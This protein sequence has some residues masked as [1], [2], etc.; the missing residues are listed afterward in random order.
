M[1]HQEISTPE[2]N[3]QDPDAVLAQTIA[4]E[5]GWKQDGSGAVYDEHGVILAPS[6]FEL[7]KVMRPLGWFTPASAR[8]S[9]VM[10]AEVPDPGERSQ[11]VRRRA[12]AM[13][14]Y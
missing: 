7:A 5:T 8:G 13:G 11:M 1:T 12:K 6:L 14:I 3:W 10:W 2:T 4:A 9:G